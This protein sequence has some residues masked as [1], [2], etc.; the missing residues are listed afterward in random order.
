MRTN[1]GAALAGLIGRSP[2]QPRPCSLGYGLKVGLSAL[3]THV[4]RNGGQEKAVAQAR[5]ADLQLF[6]PIRA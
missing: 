6:V 4:T 1:K 5:R 2:G 3:A